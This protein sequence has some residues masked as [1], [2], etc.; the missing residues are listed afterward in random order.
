[1]ADSLEHD[2]DVIKLNDP[3]DYLLCCV[4]VRNALRTKRCEQAILPNFL[5]PTCK[6]S[7]QILEVEKWEPE[8]CKDIKLISD[9]LRTEK[10]TYETT[11]AEFVG[12][13][14]SRI[15][16]SRLNLLEGQT[17][18]QAICKEIGGGMLFDSTWEQPLVIYTRARLDQKASNLSLSNTPTQAELCLLP[19]RP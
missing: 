13:I 7:V 9:K 12:V 10:A 5:E 2:R 1:M 3:R 17:T 14:H 11:K 16:C 19:H 6:T 15:H 8:E 18:A 4:Q